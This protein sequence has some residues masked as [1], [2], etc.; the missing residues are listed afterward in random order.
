MSSVFGRFFRAATFGESHAKAVGAV[1]DGCPAGMPLTEKDI[2]CYLREDL[3]PDEEFGAAFAAMRTARREPDR[4]KILSGVYKG[5]TLG[6]PVAMIVE[7]LEADPSEYLGFEGVARPSHA[8]YAYYKKFGVYD[9]RGGGRASGRECVGRHLAAALA[10]PLLKKAG[11]TFK[12]AV[13]ELAGIGTKDGKGLKKAMREIERIKKE[14]DSSGGIFEI[15]VEGVPAGLGSPVFEKLDAAVAGC[16]F[17]IG[18]VTGVEFGGG[19]RI[20][21]LT[22]IAAN[23]RLKVGRGKKIVSA[24]NNSGGINGGISNGMPIVVRAAVKPTPSVRVEQETVDFYKGANV[25]LRLS[26]RYDANF[27]PRAMKAAV[28]TLM[29]LFA[30]ATIAAGMIHPERY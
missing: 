20:A 6:T 24:S 7:N 12:P 8:E 21:G 4:A 11:I 30:D 17:G 2:E 13:V 3:A 5:R 1:V 9:P 19:F 15:T 27:T 16:L 18:G 29:M 14:G 25:R 23:D 22:G 26:G 10:A 28:S